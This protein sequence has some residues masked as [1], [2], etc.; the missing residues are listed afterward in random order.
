[1][2]EIYEAFEKASTNPNN[3]MRDN[4]IIRLVMA[5]LEREME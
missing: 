2:K 5:A 3:S 1:M 4:Y